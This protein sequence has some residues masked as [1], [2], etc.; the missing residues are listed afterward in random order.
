MALLRERHSYRAFSPKPLEKSV[1]ASLREA[2]LLAPQAGG[3]RNL[4]CSFIV[5]R[6]RISDIANAGIEA[7]AKLCE[8]VSSPFIREEMIR[9]GKNF[10]WFSGVP[11]LAVV[12]CREVPVFL[13]ETV[14]EAAP[15]LWGG[16]LSGAMGAF[17]LLL[18]AE[19]LGL[20]A[21]CLTGPLAVRCVME[22]LLAVPK[23]ECLVLLAALGHKKDTA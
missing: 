2:F 3:D 22:G 6:E 7:F 4:E 18:T 12:T 16:E 19:S 17:A 11:A 23:R 9:Y 5:D 1:L 10:F 20:G 15:L 8:G 14:G 21:C 13:R